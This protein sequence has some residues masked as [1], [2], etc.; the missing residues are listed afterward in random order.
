MLYYGQIYMKIIAHVC[1]FK[2]IDEHEYI[3]K[4][5]EIAS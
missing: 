1:K 5:E 2:R 3:I 4:L